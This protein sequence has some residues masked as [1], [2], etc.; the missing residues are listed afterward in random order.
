MLEPQRMSM[1]SRSIV[2]DWSSSPQSGCCVFQF[3]QHC[4]I[5]TVPLHRVRQ[6]S[7][8]Q[9]GKEQRKTGSIRQMEVFWPSA[10]CLQPVCV[11]LHSFVSL[12]CR[13]TG[14]HHRHVRSFVAKLLEAK[15]FGEGPAEACTK[16]LIGD[17]EKA[18]LVRWKAVGDKRK[19]LRRGS[20][21]RNWKLQLRKRK[22]RRLH[23][24]WELLCG[25]SFEISCCFSTRDRICVVGLTVMKCCSFSVQHRYLQHSNISSHRSRA[26]GVSL[27]LLRKSA[28]ALSTVNFPSQWASCSAWLTCTT[29]QFIRLL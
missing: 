2:V 18:G 15:Q 27:L 24:L 26:S 14:A 25:S 8:P 16:H 7:V 22:P 3:A 20:G 4:H 9:H 23:H 17:A 6:L 5:S 21:S 12:V 11:V 19:R 28:I 1:S 10:E 13:C 29:G